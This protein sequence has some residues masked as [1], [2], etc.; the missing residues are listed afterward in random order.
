IYNNMKNDY[1]SGTA[2]HPQTG[3][4]LAL[5]STPSYDVYP[6]MYGMS[7]E[8]ISGNENYWNESSLKISAIEQVNLLKNMKQH[9]MHFDNKAIEKVENSMTLKQKDTYK[10]VGKTGTGIV[11][12][13]E[14]NGWF[15]GY[16]ETKDNTYYFA[17]HLKGEDNAN[18]EKAQQISE[19]I[20]KEMELI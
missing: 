16:V 15:V 19:R 5:V 10:Y 9:N 12:H 3:E 7:N 13:K 2:I 17:T 20:L 8:E 18:G 11:N 1:G 6:F 4:L 14:A